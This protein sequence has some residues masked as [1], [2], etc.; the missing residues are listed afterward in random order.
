LPV[1][2]PFVNEFAE[3]HHILIEVDDRHRGGGRQP[4]PATPPCIR[5]RTRRFKKVALT[6]LEQRGKA[7]DAPGRAGLVGCSAP[8]SRRT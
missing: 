1:K 4:T 7:W 2:N 6:V 5:V 3:R 8:L